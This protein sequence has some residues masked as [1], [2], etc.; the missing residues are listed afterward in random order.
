[1]LEELKEKVCEANIAL[2]RHGLVT[3]TWGNASAIDREKGLVER[4]LELADFFPFGTPAQR[5]GF[6]R[7]RRAAGKDSHDDNNQQA[8]DSVAAHSEFPLPGRIDHF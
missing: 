2:V 4:L 8:K 6:Q 1:M 5:G 7:V 3:L